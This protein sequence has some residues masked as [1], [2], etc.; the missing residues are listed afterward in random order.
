MEPRAV[1]ADGMEIV[2]E[3][4]RPGLP[5]EAGDTARS[6]VGALRTIST[7]LLSP[8]RAFLDM[9]RTGGI[10]DPL[11]YVVLVGTVGAATGL[12]WQMLV[13]GWFDSLGMPAEFRGMA[14]SEATLGMMLMLS[15]LFVV[16][17]T[18]ISAAIYHAML[19]MFGGAPQPFETTFRVVCFASGSSYVLQI[20]PVCG[21]ILAG[22][23]AVVITIIGLRDAHG[24]TGLRAAA[25][26][27]VP[28]AL[29]CLC[30]ALLW[31]TLIGMALALP[32]A[33]N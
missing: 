32:M 12:L 26:V 8:S 28:V 14:A 27:L 29:F 3:P 1:N 19:L 7:V 11:L 5:W 10:G 4:V 31:S 23:W 20:V 15:P 25:A 30:C 16:V 6:P 17:T 24:V 18:V 21:G 2:V 33:V 9:R 13:S 22:L